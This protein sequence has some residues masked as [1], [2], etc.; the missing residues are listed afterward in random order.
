M[1]NAIVANHAIV[2]V[3]NETRLSMDEFLYSGLGL[4]EP[5]A[6]ADFLQRGSASAS[7]SI[8]HKTQEKSC[9]TWGVFTSL[10]HYT[11]KYGSCLKP[12]TT[13]LPVDLLAV[14]AGPSSTALSC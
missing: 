1:H 6:L 5:E 10:Q 4:T 13:T 2:S 3:G 9:T 7:G 14:R 11:L 8:A 12:K